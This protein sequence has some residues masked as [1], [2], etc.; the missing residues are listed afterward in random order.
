M[1]MSFAS[2]SDV[3]NT[4]ESII[5]GVFQYLRGNSFP[6]QIDRKQ[7]LRPEHLAKRFGELAVRDDDDGKSCWP[8]FPTRIPRI[9]Y[10]SAMRLYGSDKPDMRIP[11]SVG[12]LQRS[13]S[14]PSLAKISR[15]NKLLTLSRTNLWEPLPRWKIP[16]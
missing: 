16:L 8:Q 15:L 12:P 1:E 2:S 10:D 14:G 11:G 6:R 4:V 13:C 7:F 3:R 9:R 5:R